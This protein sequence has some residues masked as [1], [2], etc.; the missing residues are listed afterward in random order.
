M[1]FL[2]LWVGLL[3]SASLSIAQPPKRILYFSHTAAFRHVSI[4]AARDVLRGLDPAGFAI[5][6]SEDLSII[7]AE[8]LRNFDAV[9]FYTSG[10][11]ALSAQQKQDLLDYVLN[12]GGFAG[13]H[14]ATDTLYS[15]PEYGELIGGYP[16]TQNVR[17]DVEDP[18][19]PIT[20]GLPSSF[21]LRE[22]VYQFRA[23]DRRK[24]R[25]LLTLDTRIVNLR[26][27]G[28]NRS[29]GDFA[30]AWVHRYGRGRVFYTTLGH[31]DEVFQD[32]HVQRMLR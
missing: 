24:T 4:N 29:D 25:V 1:R 26:A 20:R 5:T 13:T 3:A 15:W 22:E 30:Q 14:S 10:E 6:A 23:F 7:T 17:I 27:D 18:D 9:F 31:F 11:L 28:V 19:H 12:G 8:Q 21:P 2:V 32:T 16:W